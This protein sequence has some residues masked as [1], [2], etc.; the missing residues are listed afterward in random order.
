MASNMLNGVSNQNKYI[1]FLSDGFPT[2]YISSGYS[3]YDPYTSWAT[4]SKQGSFYDNVLKKPCSYGTSYSDEAAIRARK[5]AAAIKA[6]GTTIFSIGVDVAGQTIQQYIT[7]SENADGFSVVDRTGTTYEI[8]DAS[9]TEAY[10]SWLR[11]S[12]GSGYYYDSTNTEGL[13]SAYNQIFA[14]IKHKNETGAKA[15]WVASDPLPKFNGVPEFVEFIGFFKQAVP[16][17][18]KD[19]LS[20]SHTS[21]GENTASF[22]TE[23]NAISWDLKKS[24]YTETTSGSTTTYTYQLVYRVRLKNESNT[25]VEED[26]YDTNGTTTL[27]YRTVQTVDGNQTVSDPKTVVFPIPSVKGYLSEL[28]FTKVDQLGRPLAGAKF[29]LAHD[30][31]ACGAC[32][33]DGKTAVSITDMTAISNADGV[34]SFTGIPSG[35]KYTLQETQAPV[36][37]IADST[38][39]HVIVA[40]NVI[41]VDPAI[42]DD[43]V[44]NRLTTL[45]ISKKVSGTKDQEDDPFAFTLTVS[46]DTAEV[47]SVYRAVYTAAGADTASTIT[48]ADG[49]ATFTLTHGQQ[50]T[51]YGLPV[52]TEWAIA[53]DAPGYK[54]TVNNKDGSTASGT[55]TADS[56]IAYTNQSMAR[57]PDTGG[58]GRTLYT[59]AGIMLCMLSVLLYKLLQRRRGDEHLT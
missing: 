10:K 47:D 23:Q 11:N 42:T 13:K 3:G 52:G 57:L 43:T 35:H 7:Q 32:R 15:D 18:L 12:I 31:A 48:V 38:V 24:G 14:E 17:E 36:G 9:S 6:S 22:I 54:V 39:Y 16:P 37:A 28:S 20:G 29:T 45:T 58:P 25:F 19:S 55:L 53:E 40:Y 33:G 2:T 34:V 46:H 41:T 8:G 4:S 5:K 1:I 21:G 27:R 26:I 30:T 50:V 59:W 56:T 49:K 51:I 44:A